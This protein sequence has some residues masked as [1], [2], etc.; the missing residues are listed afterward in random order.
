MGDTMK[1]C[2]CYPIMLRNESAGQGIASTSV[3]RSRWVSDTYLV[4]LLSIDSHSPTRVIQVHWTLAI[5]CSH[6][7]F[8]FREYFPFSIF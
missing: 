4:A 7:E 8:V 5:S 1:L 6:R 2:N 3:F